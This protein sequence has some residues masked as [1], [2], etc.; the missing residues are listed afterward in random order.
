MTTEIAVHLHKELD[1]PFKRLLAQSID[2][3]HSRLLRNS[4]QEKPN[5]SKFFRQTLY[6]EMEDSDATP[7]CVNYPGCPVRR[8]KKEI[9]SPVRYST[10][11]F[12]YVG[13]VDGKNSFREYT[14]GTGVYL[15][16]GK[17]S[18]NHVFWKLENR[19]GIVEG[20]PN[21]PFMRFDG[22]FDHP[23]EVM[24]FNCDG[25]INCDYWDRPYPVSGDVAQ[26]IIQYV[27]QEY[28]QPPVEPNKEIQVTPQNQE[29]APDGR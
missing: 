2:N 27:V 10:S 18:K 29:H 8:T 5:E 7:E 28:Q 15:E 1:E 23:A 4:L 16:A 22:V 21:L 3:W 11:L 19:R 14:P 20:H 25:G 26:Q 9:P 12:D 6:A 13:S 24:Q 17:Y